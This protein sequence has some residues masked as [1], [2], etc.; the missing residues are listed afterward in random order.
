MSEILN[1][2]LTGDADFAGTIFNSPAP[3]AS[4]PVA[5]IGIGVGVSLPVITCDLSKRLSGF[6][7]WVCP[8]LGDGDGG[9]WRG[10]WGG[11]GELGGR[12]G[13][14]GKKPV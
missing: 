14:F 3:E 10:L 12:M 7:V 6:G 4:Y 8:A 13:W 11:F 2:A 9:L 5:A 1:S